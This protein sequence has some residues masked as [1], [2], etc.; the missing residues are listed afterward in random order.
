MLYKVPKCGKNKPMCNIVSVPNLNRIKISSTSSKW[1]GH[2]A[3]IARTCWGNRNCDNICQSLTPIR[4]PEQTYQP[5]HTDSSL[6]HLYVANP[7]C[8][9]FSKVPVYNYFYPVLYSSA[10]YTDTSKHVNVN[11]WLVTTIFIQ[12]NVH[13]QQRL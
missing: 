6:T 9:V 13:V 2:A 8:I 12:N 5:K 3:R 7:F 10:V 11:K 4:S 1:N